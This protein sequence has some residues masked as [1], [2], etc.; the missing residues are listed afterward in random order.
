[1]NTAH[2]D[3][4]PSYP[5]SSRPSAHPLAYLAS[6]S[7]VDSHEFAFRSEQD[8]LSSPFGTG[9]A[10][11]IPLYCEGRWRQRVFRIVSRVGL[12]CSGIVSRVAMAGLS[13]ARVL[14][15]KV[16]FALHR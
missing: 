10:F 3:E 2:A 6:C 5:S 16:A 13:A 8:D 4:S 14:V 7:A 9:A 15:S 11:V 12:A 1:M